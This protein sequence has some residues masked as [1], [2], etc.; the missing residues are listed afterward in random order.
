M[1]NGLS[2]MHGLKMIHR[3]VKG[4]N[5]LLTDQGVVKL[6][7]FGVT[8]HLQTTLSR[9]KSLVG[10]PYW[11]APEVIIFES[12]ITLS[13]FISLDIFLKEQLNNK[14]RNMKTQIGELLRTPIL[15]RILLVLLKREPPY[16]FYRSI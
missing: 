9:T 3:D 12:S 2:H 6:A 1:M 5:V 14:I 15:S 4:A 11:I 8:A 13:I 7:D 16:K 10:T